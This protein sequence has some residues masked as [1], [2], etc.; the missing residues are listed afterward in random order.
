MDPI[1]VEMGPYVCGDL[2]G[3]M[4]SQRPKPTEYVSCNILI[5]RFELFLIGGIRS[6]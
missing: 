2:F 6:K 5:I 3:S 1:W 4:D